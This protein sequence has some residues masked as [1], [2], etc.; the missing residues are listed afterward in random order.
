MLKRLS[1]RAKRGMRG[2]PLATVAFY[3][4]DASRATKVV[5][6]IVHSE[7]EEVCELCDW[8]SFT[9]TCGTTRPLQPRCWSLWTST[10][11]CPWSRPLYAGTP[12]HSHSE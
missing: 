7:H 12:R 6:G 5:V 3:G 11:F 8:K 1:K 9:V 2:W 4:P 10:A